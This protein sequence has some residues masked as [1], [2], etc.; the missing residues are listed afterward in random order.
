MIEDGEPTYNL[1]FFR[2]AAVGV[3]MIL[4]GALT[5]PPGSNARL[6]SPNCVSPNNASYGWDSYCMATAQTSEASH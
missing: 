6:L 2:A 3:G 4:R 1:P 5:S